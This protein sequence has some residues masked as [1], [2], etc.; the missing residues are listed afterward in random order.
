MEFTLDKY[1]CDV[2]V[3]GNH[4]VNNNIDEDLQY[5]NFIHY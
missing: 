1:V 5:F 3:Y 4:Q 2:T